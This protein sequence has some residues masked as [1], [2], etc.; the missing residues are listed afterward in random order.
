MVDSGGRFKMLLVDIRRAGDRGDL[1]DLHFWGDRGGVVAKIACVVVGDRGVEDVAF[2]G[3]FMGFP[4]FASS[5]KVV[6]RFWD[7]GSPNQCKNS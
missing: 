1:G 4:V 3:P 2:K 7:S 6:T 5:I